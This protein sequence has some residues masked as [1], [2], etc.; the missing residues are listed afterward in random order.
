MLKVGNFFKF[1]VQVAV[2]SAYPYKFISKSCNAGQDFVIQ[3]GSLCFM[4]SGL[5]VLCLS[6]A[7]LSTWTS[8]L[9]AKG[10]YGLGRG[11]FEGSCRA[12]YAQMFTGMY[13]A[14]NI[15]MHIIPSCHENMIIF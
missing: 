11:V 5:L 7:Q 8:I 13:V 2:L 3:F 9:C 14:I 6:D 1:H 15:Y 10:L 4:L 12:V